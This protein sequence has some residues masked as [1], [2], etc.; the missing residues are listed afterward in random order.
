MS[1]EFCVNCGSLK[2]RGKICKS[3]SKILK[4]PER[5]ERIKED[6]KNYLELKKKKNLVKQ[7]LRPKKTVKR[8][9]YARY[10]EGGGLEYY[11]EIDPEV[12]RTRL[13]FC[14][15]CKQNKLCYAGWW[16][17]AGGRYASESTKKR[18]F[19]CS[20]CWRPNKDKSDK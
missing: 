16:V 15:K 12:K 11:Y 19:I 7:E 18:I 6:Q 1:F 10:S 20:D 5:S 2:E 3:C 8:M 4:S 14:V 9:H 17:R 13:N